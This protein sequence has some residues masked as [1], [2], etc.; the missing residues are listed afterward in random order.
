MS[1]EILK[2]KCVRPTADL[3][4]G[5]E[6]TITHGKLIDD[7]GD[8]RPDILNG[9]DSGNSSWLCKVTITESACGHT[10]CSIRHCIDCYPRPGQAVESTLEDEQLDHLTSPSEDELSQQT[11]GGSA[12]YYQFPIPQ[13][14]LDRWNETGNI[15]VR[16]VVRLMLGNDSAKNNVFKALVR[17]GEK[18]G[19]DPVYDINKCH[20]FIDDIK[21]S[22]DL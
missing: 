3:T 11:D 10:K 22:L 12:S 1:N 9:V 15:E 18:A 17:L 16:D 19:V 6:Y 14:M 5:R 7:V 2:V 13:Y 20:F 21:E 4:V 8:K